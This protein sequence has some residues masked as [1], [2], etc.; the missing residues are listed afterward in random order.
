MASY[1]C[2]QEMNPLKK[3]PELV[4]SHGPRRLILLVEDETYYTDS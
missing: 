2:M 4:I 1:Y 3:Q